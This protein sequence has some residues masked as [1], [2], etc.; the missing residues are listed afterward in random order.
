[1]KPKLEGHPLA[2]RLTEKEKNIG[3]DLTRN[4]VVYL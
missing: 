3:V 4:M 2:G 1:M